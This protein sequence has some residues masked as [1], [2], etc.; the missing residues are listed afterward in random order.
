VNDTFEQMKE[1]VQRLVK[2]GMP[3]EAFR[4]TV[5]LLVKA[6]ALARIG[7]KYHAHGLIF[8]K[9]GDGHVVLKDP[10]GKL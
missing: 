7:G 1:E 8:L 9:A 6:S 3:A 10:E 5:D 2:N 4:K